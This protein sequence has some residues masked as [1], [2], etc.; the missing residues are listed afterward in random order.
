MR[1]HVVHSRQDLTKYDL[2]V[3]LIG[4]ALV[5]DSRVELAVR[6]ELHAHE[7]PLLRVN[8]FVEA[9]YIRMTYPLH[10]RDLAEQQPLRLLVQLDLVQ[11][12]NGHFLARE[13]VQAELDLGEVARA[14]LAA[15][16]VEADQLV[17]RHLLLVLGVAAQVLAELLEGTGPQRAVRLATAIVQRVALGRVFV[18]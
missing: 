5:G 2:G 10:A 11:D 4:L 13:Q 17:Q 3:A 18:R 6:R 8:H 16:P 7:Q 12:F 14:D 1:V 9:N 15:D